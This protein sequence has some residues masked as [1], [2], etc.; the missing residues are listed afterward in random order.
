[1]RPVFRDWLA[2]KMQDPG[3]QAEMQKLAPAYQ[4]ARLR[5]AQGLTQTELAEKVGTSQS[6]IARLESGKQQPSLRFLRLVADALGL[7]LRVDLVERSPTPQIAEHPAA[8][9]IPTREAKH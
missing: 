9:I 7:D 1:M 5:I 3:F 8:Y 6:S 2:E 4:V